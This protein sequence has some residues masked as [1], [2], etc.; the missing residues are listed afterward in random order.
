MIVITSANL[1]RIYRNLIVCLFFLFLTSPILSPFISGFTIYIYWIIP[2]F[3]I[4]F[5]KYLYKIQYLEKSKKNM[6]FV[7]ML[8]L[9]IAYLLLTHDFVTIVKIGTITFTVFYLIYLKQNKLFHFLYTFIFINIF[10]AAVQFLFLYIDPNVSRMLGPSNI[11]HIIW[12]QYATPTFT[13]F[14]TI[15][16]FPRVSGLSREAGFFSTL[17]VITFI[18]YLADKDKNE[19]R[20]KSI[21]NKSMFLIGLIL[22]LSKSSILVLAV[23]IIIKGKKLLDR[24]PLFI[25]IALFLLFMVVVSNVLLMKGYYA[26]NQSLVHRLSG[27]SIMTKM[28]FNELLFGRTNVTDISVFHQYSFLNSIVKY[29]Q[30]A[31]LPN[32]IIHKGLIFFVILVVLMKYLRFSFSDFLVITLTSA[33]TDYFTA[34]SFIILGYYY[35]IYFKDQQEQ[36]D[37]K[38]Y[39]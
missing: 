1:I 25:G 15:F 27:Y 28:P 14:F 18:V 37:I 13:N 30:F 11:S 39:S 3:D 36:I 24:I 6:G 2:L 22:S 21:I 17:V 12:G 8:L 33:T 31:G 20:M 35:V 10:I 9:F 4:F 7:F 29:K 26:T 19:T 23:W 5:L 32:T 16:L 38:R 34:T